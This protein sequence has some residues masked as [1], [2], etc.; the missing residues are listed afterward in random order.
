MFFEKTIF[1]IEFLDLLYKYLSIETRIL[2]NILY[3]NMTCV[4][5]D[6]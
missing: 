6:R 3:A 1:M 4:G 2:K 5:G